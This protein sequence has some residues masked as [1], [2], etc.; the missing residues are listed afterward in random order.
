MTVQEWLNGKKTYL[1]GAGI[2]L[3][4]ILRIISAFTADYFDIQEVW[5]GITIIAGGFGVVGFRNALDK[6]DT[7]PPPPTT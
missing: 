4:G 7:P 2:V 1:A 5:E 6:K 3:T